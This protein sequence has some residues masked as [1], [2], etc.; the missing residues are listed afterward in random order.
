MA[1]D[2]TLEELKKN[3]EKLGVDLSVKMTKAVLRQKIGRAQFLDELKK[4][5]ES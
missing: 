5:N 1:A 4:S 3:A 2:V